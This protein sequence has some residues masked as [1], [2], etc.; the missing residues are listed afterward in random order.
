MQPSRARTLAPP[1]GSR[2]GTRLNSYSVVFATIAILSVSFF[3]GQPRANA[4]SLV[5][6]DLGTLGGS[7]TF[8]RNMSNTGYVTGWSLDGGGSTWAY[9]WHAGSMTNLGGLTGA[10][11][12][13]GLGVDDNGDVS[14]DSDFAG[15]G[16]V[17]HA[18]TWIGGA[19]N[20][21][22]QF[23]SGTFLFNSFGYGINNSGFVTGTGGGIHFGGHAF[24]YDPSNPPLVDIS[25]GLIGVGFAINSSGDVAGGGAKRLAN[26]TYVP[27]S[28][29]AFALLDN[30]QMA[31]QNGSQHATLYSSTGI[32]T[33]LGTLPGD[34]SSIAF[35]L[36]TAGDVV[37]ESDSG[38]PTPTG[39]AFLYRVGVM[40]DINS[41]IVPGS[42][43]VLNDARSIN[44][45]GVIVGNGLYFGQ[46]RGYMLT[47]GPAPVAV[48]S[49]AV[50]PTSVYNGTST[51]ATVTLAGPSDTAT[52]PGGGGPIPGTFV[53]LSSDNPAATF[54]IGPGSNGSQVF[55][56]P[57]ATIYLYIPQGQTSA[58]ISVNT[59]PVSST[60]TVN[61]SASDGPNVA[62][63]LTIT[64]GQVQSVS[65]NPASVYNGQS[66]TMTVTLDNPA[67]MAT[68]PG[69]GGPI[70]GAFVQLATDNAA[71]IFQNGPGSNGSQVFQ[72]PGSTYYLY[73]PQ[74]QTTADF[75]INTGPVST[76]TT[77]T[78]SATMNGSTQS[79]TLLITTAAVQSVS[80]N[81]ASVY[82]GTSS[83]MTVT[84][85]NPAYMGTPPGGGGPIAGA[86]IQLASDNV[87]AIFQNGPGSNGSQVFQG[88]GS[89]YYLY[90][91]QGQTSAQFPINTGPVSTTT[92]ANLSATLNGS[93][94]STTLTI[95]TAQVVSLSLNP[96]ALTGP[97]MSTATV[98]LDNPAYMGTPPGGGGPIS[99]VFIQLTSSDPAATFQAG[100]GTNG[101]QVF[102]GPG[103]TYYLYLPQGQTTADFTINASAVATTVAA[104][105]TASLFGSSQSAT[106][107]I[108][109]NVPN[110]SPI[111]TSIAPASMTVTL[112][113]A[114]LT[115]NGSNFVAT[116]QVIWNGTPLATTF[117]SATRLTADMP[118]GTLVTPG[119]Y[120]VQ[121]FNPALGGGTSG[122]KNFTLKAPVFSSLTIAPAS[123]TGGTSAT[124]TVKFNGPVPPGS[125]YTVTLST[126]DGN[127]TIPATVDVTAGNT[128]AT[129]NIATVPVLAQD[130]AT[131]TGTFGTTVKSD[132][133]TIKAS[134]I[135]T[136]VVN[137]TNTVGGTLPYPTITVT[138][139]G[140]TTVGY[141]ISLSS[142]DRAAAGVPASYSVP[143]GSTSVTIPITTGPVAADETVTITATDGTTTKS[144]TLAMK[145]ATLL[146]IAVS[147]NPV[148]GGQS[149][150]V[151]AVL[152]GP[153]AAGM[154][155]AVTS[156]NATVVPLPAGTVINIAPGSS[157]GTITISTNTVTSNKT[158]TIKGT[159]N[160]VS[161]SSTLSIVP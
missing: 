15:S 61:L 80:V 97:G 27:I 31:G 143:A 158:S 152:T 1:E 22:G 105:I 104:N 121:V 11:N 46:E 5:P 95:T 151:T 63:Q 75:P 32:A 156:S 7:A 58:D 59:G 52:P 47:V 111:L 37:G 90:L 137:P 57:G 3:A 78:L 71:A 145:A 101:S 76:A 98:T 119:V 14:G 117:V 93:T 106:L 41:L 94:Q 115:V 35:G 2:H 23:D 110:P 112:S 134:T 129:F 120:P 150:V 48:Q 130:I 55:N 10:S 85:D 67:F 19:A 86:F 81:P 49:I 116:S 148:H 73:L 70:A 125:T 8:V 102:Q 124:G 12:S 26:G 160:G 36:N 72:G 68:P 153:A 155:V 142:S 9:L 136:A 141:S 144:D 13:E 34:T 18:T 157:T 65:V 140:Q 39:R 161:K 54:P 62:T 33:D 69:G 114:T 64:T 6:V 16:G 56:G 103:A 89:T 131:V 118:A 29:T 38:P 123:V 154:Q 113:N 132:T 40:V 45:A 53:Q 44:D 87:A 159:L 108:G 20:D 28:G 60:T 146:S 24:L 138:F 91:P 135:K 30:G 147:P 74:G 21:L 88:P 139:T 100:P 126:T 127:I 77:A 25:G 50:N 51:T 43:W 122:T 99:G 133:L 107:T 66:S 4:Q 83:T 42:G 149:T 17:S 109:Q 92:I 128:T 82:N 84:L 96:N 79:A